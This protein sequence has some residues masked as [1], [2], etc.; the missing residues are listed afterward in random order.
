MT[1]GVASTYLWITQGAH[2]ACS[3]TNQILRVV[4]ARQRFSSE[5]GE[6][7][8]SASRREKSSR[9]GVVG[10]GRALGGLAG[11]PDWVATG[12]WNNSQ[13]VRSIASRL[14]MIAAEA[15]P[16]G[17]CAPSKRSTGRPSRFAHLVYSA[18]QPSLAPLLDVVDNAV[19]IGGK[20]RLHH[21]PSHRLVGRFTAC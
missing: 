1:G 18:T 12:C 3:G 8:R 13:S 15:K 4:F 19:A 11:R 14:A 17:T 7:A 2:P 16:G 9:N 21:E 6:A 10:S 5:V 20:R